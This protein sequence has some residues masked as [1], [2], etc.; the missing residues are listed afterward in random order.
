MGSDA[1]LEEEA[2]KFAEKSAK[3]RGH[4]PSLPGGGWPVVPSA[5]GG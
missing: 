1:V 3:C 5:S 2:T 4:T